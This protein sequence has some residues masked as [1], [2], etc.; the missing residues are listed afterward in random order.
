MSFRSINPATGELVKDHDAHDSAA[1]D[2][3][4]EAAAKAFPAWRE[5]SFAERAEVVRGAARVLEERKDEW[6]ELMTREMGKPIAQSR[7]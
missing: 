4:L 1:V 7:S 5:R 3:A 2:R 6:A